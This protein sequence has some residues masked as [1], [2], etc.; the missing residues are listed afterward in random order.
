MTKAVFLMLFVSTAVCAQQVQPPNRPYH[1]IPDNDGVYFVGPEVRAPT[2]LHAEP[3]SNIGDMAQTDV[4]GI[5]VLQLI[6]GTDGSP[7]NIRVIRSLTR[8]IDSA[9]VDAIKRSQFT[10]GSLDGKSVAVKVVAEVGFYTDHRPAIPEIVIMERD[11]NPADSTHPLQKK[12]NLAESASNPP[13]LIHKVDAYY[14]IPGK[15]AKYQGISKVSALIGEDGIPTDVRVERG[16]GMGLDE[17]AV[18]AVRLYRFRPAMRS[19]KPVSER[20]TLD[21]SFLIY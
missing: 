10:P 16:I 14:P 11:V 5:C 1:Q 8:D 18:D 7:T 19:G 13:E 6:V 4:Q 21:V 2:I 3:V 17:N 12:G 20:V 9:A 15:K